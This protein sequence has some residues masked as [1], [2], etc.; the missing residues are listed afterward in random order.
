MKIELLA[1]ATDCVVAGLL[2]LE[3]ERLGDL[4]LEAGPVVVCDATLQALDDAVERVY[5]TLQ[6]T[7]KL[8]DT[9]L[10]FASDNGYM[11]GN[12]RLEGKGKI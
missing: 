3:Q 11:L 2:E 9:L 10:I 8:A 4:L 6:A 1:Y 5:Q 12:H 7:G